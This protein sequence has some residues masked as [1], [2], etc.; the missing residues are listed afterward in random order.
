MD[1]SC[2]GEQFY[3]GLNVPVYHLADS[4]WQEKIADRFR[5]ILIQE[6]SGIV[7]NEHYSM[8]FIAPSIICV[9]ETEK[10]TIHSDQGYTKTELAFHPAFIS[11]SYNYNFI[12]VTPSQYIESGVNEA[13]WL[14]PFTTRTEVYKGLLNVGITTAKR[15]ENL[16]IQTKNEMV[17]Q[18]DGYWPCRTRSY[19][20]ELLLV[21]DRSYQDA[22]HDNI[23]EIALG[24]EETCQ[25]IMYLNNS[26]KEKIQIS[27]LTEKFS[28]NRTT[29]NENFKKVTGVPVMTYLINLRMKMAMVLLKDTALQVSE[30]MY[31]VGFNDNSHF[32]RSFKKHSGLAPTEYRETYTWL[33]K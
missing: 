11:P 16:I 6:G 18:K 1:Y 19:L 28:I 8:R 30:I 2:I 13:G 27:T 31:R 22:S 12:R 5:L 3:P 32:V 9:N 23:M 25:I 7:G 14:H 20:L 21:V 33:Y 26:Y 4:I 29:L 17:E 15:V 24:M 10:I